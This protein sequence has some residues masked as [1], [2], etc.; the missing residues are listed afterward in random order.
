MKKLRRATGGRPAYRARRHSL[1]VTRRSLQQW[2]A[3]PEW[4][5]L[6]DLLCETSEEASAALLSADP[7]DPAAIARAQAEIRYLRYFMDGDIADAM[8]GEMKEKP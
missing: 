4:E 8:R 2:L 1:P 7:H 5:Y 6:L 3:R